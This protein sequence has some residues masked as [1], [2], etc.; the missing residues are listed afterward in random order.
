MAQLPK[1]QNVLDYL[2]TEIDEERGMTVREEAT[3]VPLTTRD[4]LSQSHETPRK[5]QHKVPLRH[6]VIN[7]EPDDTFGLYTPRR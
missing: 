1:G 2:K 5:D 4:P 6:A 7:V 3:T